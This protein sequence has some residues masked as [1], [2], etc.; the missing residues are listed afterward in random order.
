MKTDQSQIQ[1]IQNRDPA[2]L[3]KLFEETNPYLFKI[4]NSNRIFGEAREDIVQRSWE[5]FFKNFSQF[6]GDSQVKV[7]IAGI[8][9]N[10][11]REYRREIKKSVLFDEAEDVLGQAFTP[12]GW[13]KVDPADPA[14]LMNS[15]EALQFIQECLQSLTDTQREAFVLKEVEDS[16]TDEICKILDINISHLGV[17]IFRAKDKL[18]K[19]LT[20]KVSLNF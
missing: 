2:T 3:K 15:K 10:K 8:L 13:W 11:I 18:R 1:L 7:F 20:G 14:A 5:T 6:K 16:G 12:E 9:I 17:L 4:L 19:C